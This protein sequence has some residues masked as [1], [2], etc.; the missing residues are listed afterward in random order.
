[1]PFLAV[2]WSTSGLRTVLS[3]SILVVPCW[4]Y[5]ILMSWLAFECFCF[6]F[7]GYILMVWFSC[8]IILAGGRRSLV[9][10]GWSSTQCP[11]CDDIMQK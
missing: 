4:F 7:N 11:Q 8:F 10:R 6:A 1:M 3:K 2:L 9:G 5:A